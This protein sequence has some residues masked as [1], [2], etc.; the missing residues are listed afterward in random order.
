MEET[1]TAA[2][3]RQFR[4]KRIQLSDGLRACLLHADASLGMFTIIGTERVSGQTV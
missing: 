1:Y 4:V 3:R 2:R